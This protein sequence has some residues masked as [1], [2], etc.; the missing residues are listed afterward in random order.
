PEFGLATFLQAFFFY[1]CL[2]MLVIDLFG[3]KVAVAV[4]PLVA[5][6]PTILV[7]AVL[8]SPDTGTAISLMGCAILIHRRRKHRALRGEIGGLLLFLLSCL[9]L[10]G[11]RH[12][13]IAVL[14]FLVAAIWILFGSRPV[15]VAYVAVVFLGAGLA[16]A[17]PTIIG[18]KVLPMSVPI[19][20]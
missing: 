20:V 16:H 2:A 1:Y 15:R 7:H 3:R 14:P 19:L 6:V 9:V 12:N 18:A 17:V 8:L 11:F 5:V 4:A 10:F 13:S